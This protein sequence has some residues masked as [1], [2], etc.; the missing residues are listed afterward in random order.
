M[1]ILYAS[2]CYL[3]NVGG[4]EVQLH[5]LARGLLGRGHAVRVVCQWSRP[6]EDWIWGATW[7]TDPP[8]SYEYEGVSVARLGFSLARRLAMLPWVLSYRRGPRLARLASRRI[9]GLYAPR[10]EEVAGRPEIVHA[11]R[12]GQEFLARAA[13]E[14]SR[15]R[16]LPFVLTRNFHPPNGNPQH[17]EYDWLARQAD[18]VIALTRSERDL[19]VE[20]RG[21]EAERIHVTGVCPVLSPVHD[22][23]AF[24][25]RY[26]IDG[27]YVLFLG[28]QV[29]HKGYEA[30]LAAAPLVWRKYPDLRFV[31]VGQPGRQAASLFAA[32][33]DARILHL[34]LVDQETKTSALAGCE[35]LCVPSTI[36]S[37]GGV[38]VEAWSFG[39][40]VVACRLGSLASIVDDER[41]G[42]LCEQDPEEIAERIGWLVESP[43]RARA[44]GEAGRDEVERNYTSE[45]ITDRVDAIYRSL[46]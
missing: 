24:R 44:M 31:F 19:L 26:A 12:M 14:L 38:Y 15:A 40:P 5:E 16:D 35:L 41:T 17:A 4:G 37:F 32:Q 22:V 20:Q 9:A 21:V 7:S 13:F 2:F 8:E 10:F 46:L 1:K 29:R 18:A 42:L 25:A 33:T 23:D 30:L 36:E 3:P 27:P 43:E 34:G 39:K 6:R 45:R 28:R 11:I